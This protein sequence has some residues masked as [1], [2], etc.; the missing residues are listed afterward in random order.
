M[1]IKRRTATGWTDFQP[2]KSKTHCDVCGDK[3]W[4]NPGNEKYCNGNWKECKPKGEILEGKE[5]EKFLQD[6][7]KEIGREA[8]LKEVEEKIGITKAN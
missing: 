1:E 4:I 8:F 2:N 5:A 3:L 7:E 6:Y